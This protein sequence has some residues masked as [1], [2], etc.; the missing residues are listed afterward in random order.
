MKKASFAVI[1]FAVLAVAG[2]NRGNQ[3]QLTENDLNA[4]QTLD[5]LSNDAANLASE[6]QELQNQAEQLN[7]EAQSDNAMGAQTPAD[8]NIQGM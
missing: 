3:D 1:A 6:S 4:T 5:E 7:Q 2:C 8:E